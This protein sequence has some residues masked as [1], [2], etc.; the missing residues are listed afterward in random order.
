LVKRTDTVPSGLTSLITLNLID[1]KFF[2]S[3]LL[4]FFTYLL[5]GVIQISSSNLPLLINDSTAG[6]VLLAGQ[7]KTK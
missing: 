5:D 4:I 2:L 3:S 1:F 6:N 7:R